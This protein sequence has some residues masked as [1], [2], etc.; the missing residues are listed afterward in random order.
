MNEGVKIDSNKVDNLQTVA[1]TG[2]YNDLSDKPSFADVAT[3]GDYNDLSNA[4]TKLSQFSNDSEFITNDT[5]NLTN[6][7]SKT[8]L[9]SLFD[10][11]AD[12]DGLSDVATSGSYNDLVD[13]E[14]LK[15]WVLGQIQSAIG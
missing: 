5:N 9:D 3:S 8:E 14:E 12:K 1:I 7:Y 13:I 15:N 2:S 11:K 4:P 6:Y 10:Y